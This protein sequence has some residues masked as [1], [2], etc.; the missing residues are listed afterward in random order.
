MDVL[1][2]Y[3]TVPVIFSQWVANLKMSK[4]LDQLVIL[5]LD[6]KLSKLSAGQLWS[7]HLSRWFDLKFNSESHWLVWPLTIQVTYR[8]V[9]RAS[10]QSSIARPI[11]GSGTA[12]AVVFGSVVWMSFGMA[13]HRTMKDTR[14]IGLCCS[15]PDKLRNE[16][17]AARR[18]AFSYS[19]VQDSGIWLG[20]GRDWFIVF[21]F[22]GSHDVDDGLCIWPPSK[23]SQ[24]AGKECEGAAGGV[25]RRCSTARKCLPGF[26]RS[27]SQHKSSQSQPDL[28][29]G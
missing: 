24:L 16:W 12:A 21:F 10:Q 13:A 5:N 26:A 15:H 22:K 19:R 7:T 3:K 23:N 29:S 11:Q 25:C 18:Q 8:R 14:T 9:E 28:G 27:P 4:L 17:P 2:N 1:D 20:A 6:R